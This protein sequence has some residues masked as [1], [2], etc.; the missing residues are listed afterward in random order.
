M[1]RRRD[2]RVRVAGNIGF[3]IGGV[4]MRRLRSRGVLIGGVSALSLMVSAAVAEGVVGGGCKGRAA[5][6]SIAGQR[7][8]TRGHEPVTVRIAGGA[9]RTSKF[10]VKAR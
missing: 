1:T 9:V 4:R 2:P 10:S 7:G 3:R 8:G 5:Q 6:K